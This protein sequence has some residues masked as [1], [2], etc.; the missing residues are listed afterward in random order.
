MLS[1]KTADVFGESRSGG[2]SYTQGDGVQEVRICNPVQTLYVVLPRIAFLDLRKPKSVSQP[3]GVRQRR[4]TARSSALAS[5]VTV[6]LEGY[7]TTHLVVMFNA[8]VWPQAPFWELD[9]A[10]RLAYKDFRGTLV[11]PRLP[12]NHSM[13]E[14]MAVLSLRSWR[15][16]QEVS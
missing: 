1:I 15:E 6:V 10:S 16:S 7:L 4:T 11:E 12:E 13:L 2:H 3:H 9:D 5:L 8:F 14:F